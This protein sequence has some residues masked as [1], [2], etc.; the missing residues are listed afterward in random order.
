M[1]YYKHPPPV[2]IKDQDTGY[3]LIRFFLTLRKEK[4][5]DFFFQL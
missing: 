1:G 4:K 3:F 2:F 5:H